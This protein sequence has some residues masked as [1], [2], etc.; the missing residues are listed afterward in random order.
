[1]LGHVV[2]ILPGFA[3]AM[4]RGILLTCFAM[5]VAEQIDT[6]IKIE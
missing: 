3:K 1:V 4:R 2:G 5:Q 6:R